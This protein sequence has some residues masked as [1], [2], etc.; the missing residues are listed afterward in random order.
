MKA[1]D[2]GRLQE[3]QA[4]SPPEI[5]THYWRLKPDARMRDLILAV[6]A[7]EANHRDVNH[8]FASIPKDQKSDL[9]DILG[10]LSELE[11]RG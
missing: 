1:I 3:W 4:M 8:T 2:D 5:A 11:N 7:D 9:D 6:R 10:R